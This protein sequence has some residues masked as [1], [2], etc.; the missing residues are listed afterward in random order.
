MNC[1]NHSD[2]TS[3]AMCQGCQKGLCTTCAS[4]YQSPICNTCFGSLKKESRQEIIK[5][6]ITVALLGV[7]MMFFGTG[8]LTQEK[9]KDLIFYANVTSEQT[10]SIA[11][12]YAAVATVVGWKALNRLTD[13]YFLSLSIIGW[14]FYIFIKLYASFF[15]GVFYTP[16]WIIIKV[17]K[18]YK[19]WRMGA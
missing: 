14:A 1:F 13:N 11:C 10:F 15:V 6:L 12:A 2:T 5:E 4:Y 17:R 18:L 8:L 7:V 19:I 16:F 9:L 3:V